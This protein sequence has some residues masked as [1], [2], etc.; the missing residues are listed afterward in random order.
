M[1]SNTSALITLP[2]KQYSKITR[3][4]SQTTD[5]IMEPMTCIDIRGFKSYTIM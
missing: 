3:T 1:L 2:D 5:K 4:Q